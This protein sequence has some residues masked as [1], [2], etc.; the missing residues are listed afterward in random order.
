[1]STIDIT[2]PEEG[3]MVASAE[4]RENFAAA[5][6]D[7]DNLAHSMLLGVTDGSEAQPGQIG[8]R[9]Y[10][11]ILTANA[12]PLTTNSVTDVLSLTL[13]PGDWDVLGYLATSGTSA[14][15]SEVMV[16]LNSQSTTLPPPDLSADFAVMMLNIVNGMSTRTQLQT[17]PVRM[18]TGSAT[19]IYLSC[20]LLWHSGTVSAAGSI[21]ARRMR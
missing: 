6:S 18:L 21:R 11:T 7:I 1:M 4:I 16:W 2:I 8:E 20:R 5:A 9:L 3:T 12:T 17:G 14:D 10:T 19:P 15:I 13:P